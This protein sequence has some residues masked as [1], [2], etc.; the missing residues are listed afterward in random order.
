[1]EGFLQRFPKFKGRPLYLSGESYG[2]QPAPHMRQQLLLVKLAPTHAAYR[3]AMQEA[4]WHD[5]ISATPAPMVMR[6]L[7][8]SQADHAP[9]PLACPMLMPSHFRARPEL[10]PSSRCRCASPVH[11]VSKA[12]TTCSEF[13]HLCGC[14]RALCPK[15]GPGAAESP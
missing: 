5:V 15:P 7:T 10:S 6:A 3:N 11:P 9:K 2:A 1:M 14:R 4:W 13:Q 8:A 12:M